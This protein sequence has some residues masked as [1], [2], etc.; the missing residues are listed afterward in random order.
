[1]DIT[2]ET[3]DDILWI[4]VSGRMVLDASL[5]RLR[6]NVLYGLES[7]VRK[8]VIDL[9]EVS[10]L[11]SSG[12][13]QVIAAHTSIQRAKGL[14]AFLN[15]SDRVRIVWTHTRLTEVLNICNSLDE[16]RQFVLR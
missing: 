11:D 7:G 3:K 10:Y 6:E 14:L 12:C 5:F 15:P 1:V 13:G 4:K 8:F 2:S 16:A 9:S